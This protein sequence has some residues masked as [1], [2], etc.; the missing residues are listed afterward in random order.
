MYCNIFCYYQPKDLK[1]L[2]KILDEKGESLEIVTEKVA[3]NEFFNK[4][5]FHAKQLDEFFPIY[6]KLTFEMYKKT[7]NRIL[8]YVDACKNIEFIGH[9]ILDGL[10][11]YMI[12]D[13]LIYEKAKKILENKENVIFVFE[14]FSPIYFAIKKLSCDLG[15]DKEDNY[16]L[17][18]IRNSIVKRITPSQDYSNL[19][20]TNKI[21]KYKRFLSIYSEN[22]SQSKKRKK[23]SSIYNISKMMVPLILHLSKSKIHKLPLKDSIDSITKK[24]DKKISNLNS[25]HYALIFSGG[26]SDVFDSYY[27]IID[28]FPKNKNQFQVFSVEPITTS[29]LINR[30]FPVIDFFEE[31]MRLAT[32][33]QETKE[34]KD[35]NQGI[36]TIAKKFNL[37]LLYLEKL[38]S[39]VIEGV[40]R[41]LAYSII[42]DYI[43][44]KLNLKKILIMDGTLPGFVVCTIAKKFN[45]P[46]IGVETL[47]VDDNAISSISYK[48]DKICIYGTQGKEILTGFGIDEDR[49]IVSGNP[50]YD[51]ISS[52]NANESKKELQ[53]KHHIDFSKKLVVIALSRWHDKD[54]EWMSKFIKFCNK[55]NFEIVIKLH[56]RYKINS[57]DSEKKIQFIKDSCKNQNYH[58]TFD[59][60]L[61]LLLSGSDVV[62]SDYSNVGVE[63]VLLGKPV[64]NINFIKEKLDEAQNYH[65]FGAVLYVED[66]QKFENMIND[67]FDKNF[68]RDELEKGRK[69]IIEMYNFNNDGNASKR[70]YELIT[71]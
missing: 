46:T 36:I 2:K 54:E 49:I 39:F 69:K 51:Y 40:Y 6:S 13:A 56:P 10:T 4:N 14:K 63:A 3:A 41:A 24:I 12:Q 55:N 11:H 53:E 68:N 71:K 65:K 70:I 29:F 16:S 30:N 64:V 28:Q 22:V 50:K 31:V 67:I 62:V 7:K 33:L 19:E 44:N 47:I 26:R 48:A 23:I 35:L 25:I 52:L 8:D 32:A 42:F 1:I 34:G 43:F 9:T 61:N 18:I 38:N 60:N 21:S 58:L 5:G 20:Q 15:Y 27:S 37:D 66:Y 17:N 57:F 45:L 59:M